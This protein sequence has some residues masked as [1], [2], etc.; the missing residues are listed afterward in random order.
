LIWF[1]KEKRDDANE[2]PNE[3]EVDQTVQADHPLPLLELEQPSPHNQ[4]E[5]HS[6]KDVI[7]DFGKKNRKADL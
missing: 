3:I 7:E 1:S 5:K 2:H 4:H 6:N